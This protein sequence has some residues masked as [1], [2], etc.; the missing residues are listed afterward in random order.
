[1]LHAFHKETCVI[2]FCGFLAGSSQKVD[3]PLLAEKFTTDDVVEFLTKI[4]MSQY[5]ESFQEEEISG[6]I[7]LEADCDMLE[8]LKVTSRLHQMKIMHLFRK[9]LLSSDTKY[10]ND[11]L[12][13][14]LEQQKMKMH[15]PTLKDNGIDG[16][17]I[18]EV[19]SEIMKKVLEEIGITK[20]QIT[21]IIIKYKKFVKEP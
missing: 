14:F 16:D 15:I 13:S 6:D 10:P 9:Q 17:M 12:S 7:L 3:M 4:E 19:D 2:N 18:L 11:H 21:K 5:A 8:E 1:M 20:L